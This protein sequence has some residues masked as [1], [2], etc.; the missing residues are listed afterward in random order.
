[1][2]PDVEGFSYEQKLNRLGL[3]SLEFRRMRGD[4]ID[5]YR[6]LKGL[7]RWLQYQKQKMLWDESWIINLNEIKLGRGITAA[8]S[9]V[10]TVQ[11]ANG[12]SVTSLMTDITTNT[13]TA[14]PSHKQGFIQTGI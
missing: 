4:L 5:I 3:Y 8:A 10:I 13:C 7:D 6:I 11:Q 14:S 9:S 1:M 2:I 12:N